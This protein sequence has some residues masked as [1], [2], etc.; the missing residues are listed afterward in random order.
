VPMVHAPP[1]TL[2]R[3]G[4][5]TRGGPLTEGVAALPRRRDRR[6]LACSPD[7]AV[8]AGCSSG[9]SRVTTRGNTTVQSL[10][11]W[12]SRSPRPHRLPGAR[13]RPAAGV[14]A[15]VCRGRTA[16]LSCRRVEGRHRHTWGPA[17]RPPR[18]SGARLGPSRRPRSRGQES[19]WAPASTCWGRR[20][21][22]RGAS[23]CRGPGVA[24]AGRSWP[25][26]C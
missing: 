22:T 16:T 2:G 13:R 8:T 26:S 6:M 25:T 19:P 18:R 24:R 9:T 21:A 5:T 3:F 7:G 4:A 23:R 15:T 14:C 20:A 12:P 17:L 11:W 10:W 1:H